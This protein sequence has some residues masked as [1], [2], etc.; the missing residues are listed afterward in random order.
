MSFGRE[1]DYQGIDVEKLRIIVEAAQKPYI[2][3]AEGRVLYSLGRHSFEKLAKE[4]F[5]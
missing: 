4:Y 1:E 3:M 5:I 2:S